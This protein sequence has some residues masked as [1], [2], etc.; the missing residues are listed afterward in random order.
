MTELQVEAS[1][2]LYLNNRGLARYRL[3]DFAEAVEDFS[4]VGVIVV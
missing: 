4:R 3:D 2:H 1:N